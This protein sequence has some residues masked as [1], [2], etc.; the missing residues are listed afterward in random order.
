MAE[1][2]GVD[3]GMRADAENPQGTIVE[4]RGISRRFG[5]VHA[6]RDV[7]LNL[8]R[9][10]ILGLLGENGAGKST[11][12]KILTGVL[13]PDEGT[14]LVDGE[15]RVLGSPQ[16]AREHEGITA[17]FQEPMVFP[18]LDV[19]ENIFAGRCPT[20]RGIVDWPLLYRR[21]Q[22]V[23]ETMGVKLDP[24][25]PVHE[26]GIADRQLVEIAK[27]LSIGA[28]VL[29]LDEPTAVL[30]SREIDI[31][32]ALIKTLRDSGVALMLISH[33]LDE[34]KQLTDRV[35]I[36]RDG[37]RVAE[38]VTADTEVSELISL[39]IGREISELFPTSATR[40]G[41]EIMR[42][43]GLTHRGYFHDVSFTL[44]RGEILGFAGLVGAGRTELAQALFGID[45]IDTGEVWLDGVRFNPR[46][47]RHAISCGLAYLPEN[48]ILDG[49]VPT[50][51]VPLNVTM[52]VWN[53]LTGVLG[54]FRTAQMQRRTVD[55]V[56]RVE[57]QAGRIGQLVGTLSGGNQQKV[58]LAKW[59]AAE[60]RV[61]IL[62]EPTHG[63]DIGTKPEILRI[64]AELA[65]TGV[66]VI[67]ISSELEEVLAMSTRVLVMREGRLVEE[68]ESPAPRER[69]MEAASGVEAAT[70]PA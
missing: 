50:M 35:V 43:E 66:G 68:F 44:H 17:T 60:P 65:R 61:L 59:L 26:L 28:R 40:A 33:K 47:P 42:V 37:Q 63:I 49:L 7:S 14:I 5:G 70:V 20:R 2:A 6:L 57:L 21:A 34:I 11:L 23:L 25:T 64:V 19:A 3:T 15:S 24:R 51:R 4:L 16:V 62:D 48:R 56:A 18:D 29:I 10:E 67:F 12:V 46:S 69:V 9:G 27:A 45:P 13:Q 22:D 32:F 31:L 52:A 8:R 53:Q 41:A 36:L 55:L 38:R 39:M 30:S 1:E 58:V 54:Y